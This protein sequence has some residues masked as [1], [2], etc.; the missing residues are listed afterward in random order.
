MQL[1]SV[2]VPSTTAAAFRFRTGKGASF[3]S[4]GSCCAFSG[5]ETAIVAIAYG[6]Q[7]SQES[8]EGS[9]KYRTERP[10]EAQRGPAIAPQGCDCRGV[11]RVAPRAAAARFVNIPRLANLS[12]FT[13]SILIHCS[14]GES[15][16][17][18]SCPP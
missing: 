1:I 15:N 13:S 5:V 3:A 7:G 10:N 8:E 11:C 18:P 2:L 14:P 12:I 17:S 16:Y 4:I 9:E 6:L